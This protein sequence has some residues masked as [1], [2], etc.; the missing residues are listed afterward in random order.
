MIISRPK[1][2]N[3]LK[4]LVLKTRSCRRFYEDYV[5]GEKTLV[6]L[7]D[8]ARLSSS[9]RNAQPLRFILSYTREINSLIFPMLA[10]AAY[11]KEWPGPVEGER[12]SAYI[13][14]LADTTIAANYFCDDGIA[15]QSIMLGATEKGLGGCII[16]SIQREELRERLHIPVKYE[17]IQVLALGKP[18]E[19]VVLES[20]PVSGDIKYWR[21]EKQVH[22]VP[23][24]SLEDLILKF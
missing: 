4:D 8:L 19:I 21:D 12:P 1:T 14:M 15:A 9:A 18:K 2:Y 20:L 7:V 22:H 5:I 24:R 13:V 10:W 11:L 16:A 3:M 6:E 23:K 17:I